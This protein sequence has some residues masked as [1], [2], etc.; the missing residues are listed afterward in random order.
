[1]LQNLKFQVI[2][3]KIGNSETCLAVNDID[4][5]LPLAL[6]EPPPTYPSASIYRKKGF[7]LL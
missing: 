5:V 6:F 4:L 3:G 7:I 1:M 2:L